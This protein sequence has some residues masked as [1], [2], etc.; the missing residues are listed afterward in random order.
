MIEN[1]WLF[2]LNLFSPLFFHD[3]QPSSQSRGDLVV[4]YIISC[5]RC[6]CWLSCPSVAELPP[7]RW[8][9]QVDI[10]M[11]IELPESPTLVRAK[12]RLL[13]RFL[14]STL[15]RWS[16][17]LNATTLESFRDQFSYQLVLWHKS[18]GCFYFFYF[19]NARIFIPRA[20]SQSEESR[21]E[22]TTHELTRCC[23]AVGLNHRR[24]SL[25]PESNK[26]RPERQ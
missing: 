7:L 2:C 15:L 25:S 3:L 9:G 8:W 14:F 23:G 4:N 17:Q 6:C 1:H 20:T 11:Q 24:Y 5:H 26:F 19:R 12:Q 13:Y 10:S 16:T 22:K 21:G 18:F